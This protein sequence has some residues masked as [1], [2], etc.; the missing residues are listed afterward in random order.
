M[1]TNDP[2]V[3]KYELWSTYGD[4]TPNNQVKVYLK[5]YRNQPSKVV[6]RR[7]L[8]NLVGCAGLRARIEQ[9]DDGTQYRIYSER[10]CLVAFGSIWCNNTHKTFND[11]RAVME[12]R[13]DD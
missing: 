10:H 8:V 2:V 1:K 13:V 3:Y 9:H 5:T 7:E 6:V 11:L 4:N 12:D